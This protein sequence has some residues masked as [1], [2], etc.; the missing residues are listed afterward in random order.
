MDAFLV[1]GIGKIYCINEQF[2][3]ISET[4][5]G[6]TIDDIIQTH[7]RLRRGV[8]TP[9]IA[10]FL[11]ALAEKDIKRFFVESKALA[12]E[13]SRVY[14]V[15]AQQYEDV[16]LWRK[17]RQEFLSRIFASKKEKVLNEV[18]VGISRLAIREA[19]EQGD[20][21][22]IQAMNS[23][24]DVEK[25]QN[26]M[27]SRLREWYGLHFP[28]AAHAIENGQTLARIVV[29]GG[30]RARIENEPELMNLIADSSVKTE[31][32]SQS[33]GADIPEQDMVVIQS[34][35]QQILELYKFREQLEK[36]LD[37]SMR[38]VAPNLR[39]LIGPVIGARLIGLAGGM[40]KLARFPASTIQVLGA[41]QALFRALKTGARPPKHGVI[42]QHTLVHSAPWWQRG[43]IARILAGKIA[44]A[45]RI[46]LYSG[47]YVAE[48]LKQNV[49]SRVA[50]VKRKYP[51]APKTSPSKSQKRPLKGKRYG[52][53]IKAH[54]QKKRRIDS[55]REKG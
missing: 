46:D 23:L 48:E 50:E 44:I 36:Y 45:A 22:V 24:D 1:I 16:R 33:M 3:V 14:E 2:S 40:Q 30:S 15:S 52:K 47:Q 42:F 31:S 9:Q 32:L 19:S 39:G 41:E 54:A 25:V 11:D 53:R 35:A 28:E 4:S 27:V 34:L 6:E 7:D 26:L 17:V 21:L 13:L 51:A 38:I 29:E 10:E 49:Q 55:R 37:E 43:K 18:A 12:D 5:L 20:Q 8:V